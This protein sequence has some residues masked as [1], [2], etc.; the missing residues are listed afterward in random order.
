MFIIYNYN[1]I[2]T[3]RCFLLP[4]Q[5]KTN[6][7]VNPEVI[8]IT[9]VSSERQKCISDQ[10]LLLQDVAYKGNR[11]EADLAFLSNSYDDFYKTVELINSGL[12]VATVTVAGTAAAGVATVTVGAGAALSP[13]II[14]L[15]MILGKALSTHVVSSFVKTL[16][17]SYICSAC[18]GF[19][20]NIMKDVK[21]F[22]VFYGL[23]IVSNYNDTTNSQK[24]TPDPAVINP[25]EENLFKF[26]YFILNTID[27]TRVRF[28]PN[29][30]DKPYNAFDEAKKGL[31]DKAVNAV[32]AVTKLF[33][34]EGGGFIYNSTVNASTGNSND[35]GSKQFL[36][37][38][39]L[40]DRIDFSNTR[41]IISDNDVIEYSQSEKNDILNKTFKYRYTFDE[42]RSKSSNGDPFMKN[43]GGRMYYRN[44]RL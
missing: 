35:L 23:D 6:E 11:G 40:L 44:Q 29:T 10:S 32:T 16:E 27:F 25:T 12:S 7:E 33:K 2:I 24:L 21:E 15:I 22:R 38:N 28:N 39:G 17:V 30:A 18:I 20:G 8:A 34:K 13:V 41:F 42:C 19:I 1:Y 3:F 9:N 43:G 36:F 14:S 4:M 31:K 5:Q 26:L 37:W